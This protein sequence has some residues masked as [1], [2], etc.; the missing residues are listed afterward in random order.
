MNNW[1]VIDYNLLPKKLEEKVAVLKQICFEWEERM[2]EKE[3]QEHYDRFCS[4][5]D[6]IKFIIAFENKTVI[7]ISIALKRIINFKNKKI[8]LGGIGGVC[9]RPDKRRRGIA[10]SLVKE[11]VKEL[12]EANCDIAYLCTNLKDEGMI[13]LYSQ[14]GFVTLDRSHVYLGKSGKK[15]E[16]NDAMIA[17][18]NSV[19]IFQEVKED[20]KPFNIGTGNW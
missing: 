17:P 4:Q 10:T 2:T 3:K 13:K 9:V 1:F 20:L 15:Y 19:E 7:G 16:D 11:T 14:F 5:K 8:I 18:I 6:R 12:K